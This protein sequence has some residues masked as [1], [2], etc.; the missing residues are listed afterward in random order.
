MSFP[1]GYDPSVLLPAIIVRDFD[2]D[3]IGFFSTNDSL[4]NDTAPQLELVGGTLSAGINGDHGTFTFIFRDDDFS[5]TDLENPYRPCKLKTGYEVDLRFSKQ[6]E[7]IQKWFTGI[8]NNVKN[9]S[10]TNTNVWEITA[11][12]W[13]SLIASRYSSM[14]RTQK[15]EA[16]GI[17]PDDTDESTHISEL[18]KDLITDKDHFTVPGL[19]T[20][21][22]TLGEIEDIP[23]A[24]SDFKKNFVTIG[25][26]LNELAQM[27]GGFFHI[28]ADKEISLTKRNSKSS[29]FLV[30]NDVNDPGVIT[31]NW[32]RN[33]LSFIKDQAITRDD[34]IKDSGFTVLHGVGSQRKTIDHSQL[35]SNNSIILGAPHYFPFFPQKD[36]ISQVSIKLTRDDALPQTENFGVSIIGSNNNGTPNADDV[37]ETKIIPFSLLEKLLIP[38]SRLIDIPFDK[39]PV[40]HGEKLFLYI[41]PRFLATSYNLSIDYQTGTGQYFIRDDLFVGD[42]TFTTYS[43]K[44]TRITG[45]NTVTRKNFRPKEGI[46]TLPDGPDETTVRKVFES[47]LDTKSKVT[48]NFNPIRITPPDEPLQI[49]R[50]LRLIDVQKDFDREVSLVGYSMS[51]NAYDE[52]ALGVYEMTINL[53]ELYS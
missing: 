2:N 53:Q 17:T 29:G 40:T 49:G 45:Q 5:F 21:P 52:S 31:K 47:I 20:L 27:A 50:T 3:I 41:L 48:S 32:V 9:I 10:Q 7:V 22:I 42:A 39:I 46:I 26:E 11:F 13:G 23:I 51:F 44:T 37:R 38:G 4:T 16:D 35:L 12:G 28:N 33:K 24:L 25:S 30:S 19:G 34:S 36:N 1:T 14:I 18:F 8:I 6:G 15:R 43:S